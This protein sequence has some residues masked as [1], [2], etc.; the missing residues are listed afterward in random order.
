MI[1]E[2]NF[3]YAALSAYAFWNQRCFAHQKAWHFQQQDTLHKGKWKH[4]NQNYKIAVGDFL[5]YLQQTAF[6]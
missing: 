4:H 3:G 1:Q 5:P 2:L 6:D